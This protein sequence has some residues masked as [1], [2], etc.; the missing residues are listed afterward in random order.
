[1]TLVSKMGVAGVLTLWF[2]SFTDER[3][4]G[5]EQDIDNEPNREWLWQHRRTQIEIQHW[6]GFEL[7]ETLKIVPENA[8]LGFGGFE[9]LCEDPQR[10]AESLQEYGAVIW[11]TTHP[12]AVASSSAVTVRDPDGRAVHLKAN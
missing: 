12:M 6:E 1:M 2:L 3:P 4:P 11:E 9:V 8:A 7:S 10:T 5:W